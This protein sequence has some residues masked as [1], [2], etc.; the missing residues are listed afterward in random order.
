MFLLIPIRAG[1]VYGWLPIFTFHNVSINTRPDCNIF[2]TSAL[3]TF[4][5]VSINTS[6]KDKT[7]GQGL[8]FTFHN[9]SINTCGVLTIP[10]SYH[11][12]LHSTMFLLIQ[13]Q[14]QDH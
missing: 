4:H 10:L 6:A 13:T 1:I 5:N 12:Y 9:V 11:K 14:Q 7:S 3:F 8:V 2:S